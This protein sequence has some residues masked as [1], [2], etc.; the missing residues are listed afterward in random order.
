MNK[1]KGWLPVWGL[2]G[3][4]QRWPRVGGYPLC[5]TSTALLQS[6]ENFIDPSALLRSIVSI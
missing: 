3:H 1:T 4:P 6:I 2:P 5:F